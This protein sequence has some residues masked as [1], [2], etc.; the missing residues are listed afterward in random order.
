MVSMVRDGVISPLE[1]VDAHLQRI[2]ERNASINAFV[3]VLAEEARDTARALEHS[4]TRGLLHG[5]PITV[6]DSFD[7]AGPPPPPG[8]LG[9]PQPP[10]PPGPPPVERIRA[11]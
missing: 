4:D 6:K 10:A 8:C 11:A 1:L 5:V 9:R 3:T 7:M 2:E